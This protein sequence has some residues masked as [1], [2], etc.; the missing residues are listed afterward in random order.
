MILCL[1]PVRGPGPTLFYSVFVGCDPRA[2]QITG[3]GDFSLPA[4]SVS[5]KAG[6]PLGRETSIL[7]PLTKGK[8]HHLPPLIRGIEGVTVWSETEVFPPLLRVRGGR[9]SY[10]ILAE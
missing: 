6:R 3:R 1:R 5:A 7:L 9:G 2:H 8:P 4:R 10:E